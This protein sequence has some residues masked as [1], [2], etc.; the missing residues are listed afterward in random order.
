MGTLSGLGDSIGS[1]EVGK[2]ADILILRATPAISP[3]LTAPIRNLVPNLVYSARGDE[4]DTVRTMILPGAIS[5]RELA[6]MAA[7]K[8]IM[9]RQL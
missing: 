8:P 7:L 3:I 2:L 5:F 1:L 4:V 9:N 6:P